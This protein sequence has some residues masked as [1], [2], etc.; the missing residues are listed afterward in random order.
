MIKPLPQ[1]LISVASLLAL[2][3]PIAHAQGG[4]QADGPA[5]LG[6]VLS[7]GGARGIAHVG[8]LQWFE[9]HRIPVDFLAGTSVGGLVGALYAM[10]YSPEE[11]TDLLH[12]ID[13]VQALGS[14]PPYPALSYRRKDDQRDYQVA[15]E[16]GLKQGVSLPTGVGSGHYIGLL[17]DRVTL[18]YWSLKS[19]DELPIPFRC[20]A[21]DFL[22]AEPLVLKDG[23][24]A[25]A[26]RATMS[27]PGAFPPV[28]RDGKVL[29]DGGLLDN[30]PTDVM[31]RDMSPDVIVAVDIGSRLGDLKSISTLGGILSQTLIVM[32]IESDRRNLGYADVVIVPDLGNVDTLDFS[33][34]ERIVRL[35]Y[36]AAEQ[37]SMVLGKFALDEQAWNQHLTRRRAR[38][39][40]QVPVPASVEVS[41]VNDPGRAHVARRLQ[42]YDN[43]PVDTPA[44]EES[45]TRIVGEGRY[46]SMNYGLEASSTM[47]GSS[48]LDIR[49]QEKNYAPPTLR[50]GIEI[51]GSEIN[52]IHF[53]IGARLT[54]ADVGVY[55]SEWRNEVR[56]G[57]NTLFSTE[58]YL[59]LGSSGLFAAP[60]ASWEGRRSNLF[61]NATRV[62]EYQGDRAGGGLDVGHTGRLHEFR[63]GYFLDSLDAHVR[64]GDPL[65]PSI[66]GTESY[67]RIRFS[68]DNSDNPYVP[69]RGALITAEGRWYVA[70]P[71][72][73]CDFPQAQ[74]LGRSFVPVSQRGSVLIAGSIGTS[75]NK[76]A[77]PAQQFTLGGP[78]RM[79]A[80]DRDYFRGN[81]FLEWQVGYQ[82]QIA[83]L[84]QL[85]GGR[86][87]LI[88]WWDVGSAFHDFRNMQLRNAANGG[89]VLE[90]LLGAMS[91]TGSWG[92]GG[93]GRIWFTLG[94]IF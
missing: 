49:V 33:L 17:F 69:S 70:A 26:L 54:I 42:K 30:I 65:L 77:P 23:S 21:T 38:M 91:L 90:T 52:D 76:D 15:L 1:V 3:N 82:H 9:E 45:L 39:R 88:A 29:V 36:D 10:G 61:S 93:H 44:L 34:I 86:V 8:V 85:I 11:I 66:S 41:G 35:G 48:V 12:S 64:T 16:I 71:S 50:S 94:R 46:Q 5:K 51:D 28:Y 31:K 37:K 83:R 6:L 43:Q 87:D 79:A 80:F 32:T 59:P 89:V 19:F 25:T 68:Y 24:L 73:I 4:Q 56:I 63:A 81:H 20:M 72:A 60:R 18:P 13:W 53:S 27:I 40:K 57:F 67:A 22:K 78:F 75:F 74:I 58:Y 62:A 47:A 55:G 14:Q 92:E 7:G 2:V 84:P